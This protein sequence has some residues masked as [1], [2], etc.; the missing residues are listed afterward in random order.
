MACL[1]FGPLPP[2]TT[3]YYVVINRERERT[4]GKGKTKK[5]HDSVAF[6]PTWRT[7]IEKEARM[8]FHE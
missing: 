1:F 6:V 5:T 7:I 3:R 2:S 4:R 8:P